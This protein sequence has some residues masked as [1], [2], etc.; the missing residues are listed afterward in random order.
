MWVAQ[1]LESDCRTYAQLH[2]QLRDGTRGRVEVAQLTAGRVSIAHDVD[3]L[4]D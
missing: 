2:L 4:L 3:D 1:P